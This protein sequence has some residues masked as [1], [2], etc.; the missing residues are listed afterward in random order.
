[1]AMSAYRSGDML[2]YRD[3]LAAAD[4]LLPGQPALRR[5]LAGAEARLGHPDAAAR[6]LN[7]FSSMNVRFDLAQDKDLESIRSRPD[8]MVAL[9]RQAEL[10]KPV[11]SS[12]TGAEIPEKQLLTEGIA[13]DPRP[14]R[15]FISSVHKRKILTFTDGR[16]G[17]LAP[18]RG[19]S[20]LA[21]LGMTFDGDNNSLWVATTAMAEMTGYDS[22]MEGRT[23]LRRLDLESGRSLGTWVVPDTGRDHNLND[24]VLDGRGRL[25]VSDSVSGAIYRLES[26]E[27]DHLEIFL[28]RG[29]FGS[30]NG[31]AISR[32]DSLLYVSDYTLGV[33]VIDVKTKGIERLAA[34]DSLCLNGVDG[35]VGFDGHLVMI[36]NGIVPHRLVRAGLDATGRRIRDVVTLDRAHPSWDEPTLGVLDGQEMFY[37]ARSQWGKMLPGGGMPPADSLDLP[38]VM[39]VRVR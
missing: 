34:P 3:R 4:S 5:R 2:K 10:E 39:R 32:G 36:Q 29:T 8:Y 13:F 22:T 23:E 17:T 1:E 35:L 28:P 9:A 6:W 11:R 16:W 37:I 24:L 30:P 38:I 14:R 19:E 27:H 18:A 7:R 12:I 15:L 33:Y 25:Y 21:P 31:L 26:A 20:L